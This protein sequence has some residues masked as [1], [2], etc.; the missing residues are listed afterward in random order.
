M[1]DIFNY[2]LTHKL[3]TP[4][5]LKELL[6]YIG[7]NSVKIISSFDKEKYATEKDYRLTFICHK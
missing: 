1:L 4:D 5:T 2:Q 3:W 7:F 6:K